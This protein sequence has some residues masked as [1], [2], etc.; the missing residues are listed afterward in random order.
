MDLAPLSGSISSW[1]CAGCTAVAGP[2]ATARGVMLFALHLATL[3]AVSM[4]AVIVLFMS[5]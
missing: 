5:V 3:L 2:W 1:P 4:I